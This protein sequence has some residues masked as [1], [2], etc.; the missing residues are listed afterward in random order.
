[1]TLMPPFSGPLAPASAAGSEVLPFDLPS[2]ASLRSAPRKAFANWVPSL[3]ISLDNLPAESDYY[4]KQYL[5]P[6]GEG[7]KH[8]AYGGYLRDR[9]LPRPVRPESNWTLLDLQEEVRQAISVGLDGFTT[10]IYTLSEDPDRRVWDAN[11][12]M[13]QAAAT[14]DPEFKIILQPDM[15]AGLKNKSADALAGH[16][17]QLGKYSSAY[18]L[19][20]GR[21]VVSPF[22]AESHTA[23]WWRGFLDLMR[24][25]YGLP[26][27]F[28]P[29]FQDEQPHL[30]AFAPISWGMSNW[31]NRN[32]AWN[33]PQAT[34]ATS[35]RGRAAKVRAKG[36]V[37][38][39]PVSAQ[40]ERPREGRFQ[41]SQNT[42]NL[43]N[44]WKIAI[45]SGAELIQLAT[46]NDY[47]EGSQMAPSRHN[48]WSYLDVSS[49]YLTWFKT[50]KAPVV[51][52]DTV[53]LT[54]RLH[55]WQARPS[56]PQTLLMTFPA[57]NGGSVP[58]DTVEAVTFLTA[59]GSVTVTVGGTVTTCTVPAGVATCT[60][61]LATGTVSAVTQR[62]GT[63]TAAVT[64]PYKVVATPYVQDLHYAAVSSGRQGKQP[65]P[66]PTSPPAATRTVTAVADAVAHEAA[67]TT[68]YGSDSSLFSRGTKGA[69]SYLR[70]IL[71]AAPTGTK[72]T[73]A[74]LQLRTTSDSSSGSEAAHSVRTG[75]DAWSEATLTWQNRPA[76]TATTLGTLPPGA[77]AAAPVS[78]T[79]DPAAVQ[80]LLGTQTTFTLSS[81][82]TDTLYVWAFH[83]AYPSYR[84]QLVLT[85]H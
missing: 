2:Q 65:L 58:R 10:V 51:K 82:G 14:A 1:M 70:F 13:M 40:D 33:D 27:A 84:P 46:W 62:N 11:V 75:S 15:S 42:Q 49:Y 20:D 73:A 71:P 45:D 57:K 3:P 18:R 44:T 6:D 72:L 48:G 16:I 78:V 41:E 5:N 64:S 55:A 19:A 79:L 7:G 43:R 67:P 50:G 28:L 9:P 30:E 81:T 60:V 85:F 31:G 52:R 66:E 56:Y 63:S 34:T 37:W 23:D 74:S 59:P 4:T 21:L 83:H 77:V 61:P 8:K 32:P 12:L 53:Y 22:N 69:V 39:Q 54:H 24:T 68:N 35:A 17:A 47:P 76:A 80:S 29:L 25:K 26:V 38:M 36:L